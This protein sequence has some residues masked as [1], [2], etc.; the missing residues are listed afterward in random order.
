MLYNNYASFALFVTNYMN[1]R[2]KHLSARLR[3]EIKSLLSPFF[4]DASDIRQLANRIINA[5]EK[6][7]RLEAQEVEALSSDLRK[8]LIDIF[9]ATIDTLTGLMEDIAHEEL[10]PQ[11]RKNEHPESEI[12]SLD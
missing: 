9:D 10:P 7:L 1:G 11:A 4:T 12:I 2:H 3:S 5:T 6:N 8:P